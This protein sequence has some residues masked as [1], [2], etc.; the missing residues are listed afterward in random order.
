MP[1]C[2]LI[3]EPV[4]AAW[5]YIAGGLALTYGAGLVKFAYML[6]GIMH[7]H[8]RMQGD[9]KTASKEIEDLQKA[10]VDRVHKDNNTHHGYQLGIALLD[11]K[12]EDLEEGA[13]AR[14]KD[15]HDLA[16]SITAGR[17]AIAPRID[18]NTLDIAKLTERVRALERDKG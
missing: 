6:G 14:L 4:S 7:D 10:L 1:I 15:C 3:E 2:L 16:E 8:E 9:L 11:E 17:H 18:T 12:V 13:K 5:Q